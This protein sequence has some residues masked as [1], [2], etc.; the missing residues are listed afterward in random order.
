MIIESEIKTAVETQK[1]LKIFSESISQIDFRLFFES[2]QILA[3]R[4]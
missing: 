1:P 2:T 4:D 3:K